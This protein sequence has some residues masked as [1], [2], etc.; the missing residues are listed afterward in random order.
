MGKR[1][2]FYATLIVGAA[3]FVT[4]VVGRRVQDSRRMPNLALFRAE[5]AK[6]WDQ[7]RV[8]AFA[9]RVQSR[10][11]AL[12][13][14]RPHYHHP[15]L[16]KMHLENSILPGLALYMTL[17]EEYNQ[18]AALA[19]VASLF[20]ALANCGLGPDDDIGPWWASVRLPL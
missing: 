6:E 11:K 3:A 14:D 5:V 13:A 19:I 9:E 17:R 7:A 12:M 10:Y 2:V 16:Q 20:T 18:E 4:W 1:L 8:A 15:A